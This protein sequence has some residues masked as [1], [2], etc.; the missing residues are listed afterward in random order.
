MACETR[1]VYEA[2]FVQL[3]ILYYLRYSRVWEYMQDCWKII[4]VARPSMYIDSDSASAESITIVLKLHRIHKS[5]VNQWLLYGR[6]V[7]PVNAANGSIGG[8]TT[9]MV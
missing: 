9:S 2:S 5:G 4:L 1:V 3:Q 8:M 6:D 7:V